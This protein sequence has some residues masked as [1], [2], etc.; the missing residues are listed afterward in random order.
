MLQESGLGLCCETACSGD[1]EQLYAYVQELV[2]AW[3]NQQSMLAGKQQ[4]AVE[5]Y[6][7]P[8]LAAELEGWIKE[9]NREGNGL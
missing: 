7:Y 8:L 5:K 4:D 2:R 1:E 6:G 3:K 9:N